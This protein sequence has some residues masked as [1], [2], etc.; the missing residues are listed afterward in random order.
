[1][2]NVVT[3]QLLCAVTI[4]ISSKTLWPNDNACANH[5]PDFML[6]Q[7]TVCIFELPIM[8]LEKNRH[9]TLPCM[10]HQHIACCVSNNHCVVVNLFR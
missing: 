6:L 4:K 3:G 8:R 1:M 2:E 5:D 7:V 10:L 9:H